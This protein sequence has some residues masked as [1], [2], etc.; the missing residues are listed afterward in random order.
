MKRGKKMGWAR[1]ELQQEGE[2]EDLKAQIRKLEEQLA[3]TQD[4]WQS[5]RKE[6]ERRQRIKWEREN[7]ERNKNKRGPIEHASEHP[8]GRA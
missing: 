1:R 5:D 7:S 3:R 6:L 4:A 8:G 2:I